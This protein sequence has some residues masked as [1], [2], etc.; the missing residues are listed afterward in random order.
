LTSLASSY[1]TG[2][3]KTVFGRARPSTIVDSQ[4]ID[5]AIWF[6]GGDSFPSGHVGR[7]FGIFLPLAVVLPRYRLALLVVPIYISMGR[8]IL[9]VHFLSDV[10]ASI[11]IVIVCSSLFAYL[12][13][14]NPVAAPHS[15]GDTKAGDD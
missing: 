2:P 15:T 6:V 13:K 4:Q 11:Y 14:I 3:L 5:P 9:N 10:F 12:L 1:A 8:I 7:Y